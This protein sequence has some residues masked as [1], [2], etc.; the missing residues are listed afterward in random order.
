MELKAFCPILQDISVTPERVTKFV[1]I[2]QWSRSSPT[3]AYAASSGFAPF[4][5]GFS[6]NVH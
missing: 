4:F 5:V 1:G 3:Q 6:I 2:E